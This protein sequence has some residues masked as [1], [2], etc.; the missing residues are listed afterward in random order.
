MRISHFPAFLF[1]L[2]FANNCG[3]AQSKTHQQIAALEQ[4]RFEAMTKKDIS[5]LQNILD[6]NLTYSHSN[7]L[8][9]NK[10][11]HLENI[12]SGGIVYQEMELEKS[13][14]KR[15][16]KTAVVNGIVRVKGLYKNTLFNIRLGYT[17]V[18]IKR[19]RKWKLVAW[20][21]VRLE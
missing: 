11:Q 4:Q 5:F 8:V 17:D 19:K 21:S 16:K 13:R 18:Y 1:L 15:F 9:E 14:I 20:Q 12:R 10:T 2:L 7:G 6:E 3:L